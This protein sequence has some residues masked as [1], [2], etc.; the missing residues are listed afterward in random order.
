[1]IMEGSESGYVFHQGYAYYLNEDWNLCSRPLSG[2]P[3]EVTVYEGTAFMVEKL[4][5][6]N[7]CE[8]TLA[9]GDNCFYYRYYTEIDEEDAAKIR[10]EN[11]EPIP[12]EWADYI[13]E[14]PK[15]K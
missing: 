9:F 6:V 8:C 15:R 12:T 14:L 10:F 1:M 5:R 3:E 4:G 2:N 7:D 11:Y 13:G